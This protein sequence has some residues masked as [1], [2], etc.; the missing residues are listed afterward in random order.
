[1][2][3]QLVHDVGLIS[4]YPRRHQ[5]DKMHPY[6]TEGQGT[7][8]DD[9][10]LSSIMLLPVSMASSLVSCLVRTKVYQIAPSGV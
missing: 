9:E 1:M 3:S 7:T 2:G 10:V 8:V 5:A 6:Q 4:E